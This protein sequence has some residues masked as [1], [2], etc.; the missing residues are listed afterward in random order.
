MW[1]S[2]SRNFSIVI[3]FSIMIVAQQKFSDY[4]HIIII[5]S[6]VGPV[7]IFPI[8]RTEFTLHLMKRLLCLIFTDSVKNSAWVRVRLTFLHRVASALAI[9]PGGSW[10]RHRKRLFQRTQQQTAVSFKVKRKDDQ[11]IGQ[12]ASKDVNRSALLIWEIL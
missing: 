9:N 5:I 3:V 6:T 8:Q 7:L 10:L 11:S 2:R 4:H 1:S 12:Y